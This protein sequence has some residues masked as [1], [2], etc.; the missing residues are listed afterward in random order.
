MISYTENQLCPQACKQI[1]PKPKSELESPQA[2]KQ[3]LPKPRSEL[4]S[5]V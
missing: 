2:Y 4:E 5:Y 1:L 3:I